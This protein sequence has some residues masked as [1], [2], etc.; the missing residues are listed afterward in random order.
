MS[1]SG[2]YSRLEHAQWVLERQLFW[3]TA[4]DAKVGAILAF[5][6]ALIGALAAAFTSA[7]PEVQTQWARL[8][9]VGAG[10]GLVA[11]VFCC[12]MAL[13]PRTRGPLQSLTFFVRVAE[14]SPADYEHKFIAATEAERLQDLVTQIHRNAE[15]ATDKFAFV[16]K[17]LWST[18]L[19]AAPWTM[20]LAL[21]SRSTA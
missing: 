10:A 2:E 5:D 20:A 15:I 8:M 7:D 1:F 12:A 3:I 18:F 16:K 21:L 17:A 4:A 19:S 11:S 9:C 6:T 13:L 14:H